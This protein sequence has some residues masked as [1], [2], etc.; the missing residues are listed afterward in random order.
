VLRSRHHLRW[1]SRSYPSQITHHFPRGRYSKLVLKAPTK[2][3]IFL[4][5]ANGEV[6][7][8]FFGVPSRARYRRRLCLVPSVK[9]KHYSISTRNLQLKAHA[10]EV[11]DDQ[12]IPRAI[13]ALRARPLHSHLVRERL[14]SMS[15]LYKKFTKFSKSEIQHFRK[16]EQQRETPKP[17]EAP[18]PPCYNDSQHSYPK[19]MHSIDS[20]GCGPPEDGEKNFRSPLQERSQKAFDQR[21]T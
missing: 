17:Y 18:R 1:W 13:K 11:S 4:A 15:E 19:P 12:V 20:D 6:P 3:H 16:L 21:S 14:K 5:I 2:I 9:K 7:A 10:L 8:K